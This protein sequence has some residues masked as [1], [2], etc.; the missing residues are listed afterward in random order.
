MTRPALRQLN[1]YVKA[2]AMSHALSKHFSLTTL[3]LAMAMALPLVAH[4]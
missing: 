1:P 4:A 2:V 3:S